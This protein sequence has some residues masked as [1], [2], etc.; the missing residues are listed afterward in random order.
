MMIFVD[1]N[2]NSDAISELVKLGYKVESK[3]EIYQTNIHHKISW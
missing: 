2:I 1:N 3:R